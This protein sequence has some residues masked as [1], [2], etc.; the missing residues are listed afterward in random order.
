MKHVA[1]IGG[2]AAGCFCA[3][4]LGRSMRDARVTVYEAG[5]RPMSK[6]AL[7]GGGRCNLTNS[8][9]GVGNLR[10]VYPRGYNLMKR[11][12]SVFGPEDT[13]RWFESEGVRLYTQ[14]DG[15]VFPV[16]DDAM[17]IVGTLSG[18]MERYGVALECGRRVTALDKGDRFRIGFADGSEDEADVV[19]VTSGGATAGLAGGLGI[20][21]VPEVPSLFTLRIDDAGLRS[22]MGSVAPNAVLRLEGTSLRSSGPLLV[23]DWGVS[24][25]SVLKLSSY[26][27]RHLADEGYKAGL[28]IDWTGAS[29]AETLEWVRSTI[30]RS[31]AKLVCNVH[32]DG[33]SERLW[34]HITGRAGIRDNSRWA[35]AGSRTVNRLVTALTADRYEIS[36]KGSYK[37]EFVTC[38]GVSL[39]EVEAGTLEARKC[40]GLFFAGEVL[41]IDAVTGGY[42]LQ[43]AWSTAYSVYRKILL[44]L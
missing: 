31:G 29:E 10:E 38:G 2:G 21:I 9:E 39:S 24:G 40:P 43:A 33:L 14:D 11:C 34:R 13:W 37:D 23:T 36:G 5:R 15:R 16:S 28:V 4:N 8:F 19:V 32:P 27:A 44:N 20:D 1:I 6:L 17:E 35:E 26:A 30:G 42:N 3:A 12:L 41:D 18:M 25:P 22:L 7:T